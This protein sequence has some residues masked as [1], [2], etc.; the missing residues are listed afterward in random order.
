MFLLAYCFFVFYHPNALG[1]F[2][3]YI[4]A[5][6]FVTPTHIVPEWYFLPFYA[7]LRSIPDKLGGV[8]C[9]VVAILIL[10][11]LPLFDRNRFIVSPTFTVAATLFFWFFVFNAVLLGWLGGMPVEAPF[12]TVGQ[13]ATVFYFG[14]F[15]VGLPL[16]GL[17][18]RQTLAC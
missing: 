5:N 13:L 12:V 15:A 6:P 7:I 14:Y 11:A 8:V 9:M 16:L 17:S 3:N 1:H 4:E 2:D 18:D 10:L